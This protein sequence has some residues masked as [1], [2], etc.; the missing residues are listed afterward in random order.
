MIK[1]NDFDKLYTLKNGATTYICGAWSLLYLGPLN[2]RS[3]A[4]HL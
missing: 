3:R 1:Y 4:N 2:V